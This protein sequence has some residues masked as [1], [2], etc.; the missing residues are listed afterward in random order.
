MKFRV[1]AGIRHKILLKQRLADFSVSFTALDRC[2][3]RFFGG[4]RSPF[5]VLVVVFWA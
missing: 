5:T 3:T 1:L 4:T 2:L